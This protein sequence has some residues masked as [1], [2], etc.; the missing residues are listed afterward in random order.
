MIDQGNRDLLSPR[1]R[2]H[3]RG[4]GLR[5]EA[6]HLGAQQ[7]AR[8]QFVHDPDAHA[9]QPFPDGPD[10]VVHRRAGSGRVLS[11]VAGDR[12]EGDRAIGG[13]SG[14]RAGAVERRADAHEAVAADATARRFEANDAAERGGEADRAAGVSAE[15]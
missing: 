6:A 3:Q 9:G 8:H 13:G 12:R 10:V 2:P 15:R 11:I 7:C 1:A 14:E 4:H 5:H